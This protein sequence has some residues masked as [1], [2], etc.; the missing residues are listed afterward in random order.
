[1]INNQRACVDYLVGMTAYEQG[2]TGVFEYDPV[3][4]STLE[5]MPSGV[6]T[7]HVVSYTA[8]TITVAWLPPQEHTE[9]TSKYR[10]RL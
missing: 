6:V 9:C 8:S 5:E 1:M 7:P 4:A 3:G 10:V 2:G